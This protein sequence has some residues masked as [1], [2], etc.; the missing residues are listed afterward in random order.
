MVEDQAKPDEASKAEVRQRFDEWCQSAEVAAE[1]P[2]SAHSVGESANARYRF[3]V[4]IC[5]ISLESVREGR[6]AFVHLILRRCSCEAKQYE[7]DDEDED[8]GLEEIEGS[9]EEDVG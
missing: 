2:D 5:R 3:V 1:Q 4:Q 9:T 6:A 8:E 7:D